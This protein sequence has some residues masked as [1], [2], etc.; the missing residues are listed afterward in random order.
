MLGALGFSLRDRG[1]SYRYSELAFWGG[2][3][4]KYS[5]LYQGKDSNG[6]SFGNVHIHTVGRLLAEWGCEGG[7]GVITRRN[8]VGASEVN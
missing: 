3:F 5:L 2:G 4:S 1:V 6:P 8:Y 7:F